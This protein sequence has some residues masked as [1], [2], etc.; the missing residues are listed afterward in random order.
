MVVGHNPG[1][2]G[3]LQILTRRIEALSAGSV[4]FISLPLR[5]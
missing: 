5:S 1:L 4:A 3:L 2:E